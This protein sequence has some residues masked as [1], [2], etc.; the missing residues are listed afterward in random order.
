MTITKFNNIGYML[1]CYYE[2]YA[3]PEYEAALRYSIG[4]EGYMNNIIGIWD[5]LSNGRINS[6]LFDTE[7]ECDIEEQY[8][9]PYIE[10]DHVKNDCHLDKNMIITGVNA[11]GKTTML[12]TT[13]INIIFTQQVGCGFYKKFTANPYTH[14]HSY[15]NIP[16]TSGRDS[17]FQAESRRCK[18]IIDI[19]GDNKNDTN[20]RHFCIFDELYSGTNPVEAT[21]SAY[22]F[23]MY[24][25]EY[26]NVD[27][28][29]TTHYT[30]ICKKVKQAKKRI[31]NY[32]M[33]VSRDE[34]DKLVYTYK[35]KPGIC[36]IEGAIEILKSMEYPEEI[37][38]KIKEY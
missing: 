16:D 33:D 35:M 5:N 22:A 25:A 26:K 20:N 21:K 31:R 28:I 23:L 4:F 37:L 11:A 8:Y 19:I 24:L 6:A 30:S 14:I 7:K 3:N 13:T 15:L 9:P 10:C 32:K 12:K 18:E 1:K 38:E 27:F 34:D 2:L 36:T 29:L 17:L